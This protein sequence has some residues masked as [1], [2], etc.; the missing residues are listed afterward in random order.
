MRHCSIALDIAS[1]VALF[2]LYVGE[3]LCLRGEGKDDW[4]AL[5]TG[6]CPGLETIAASCSSKASGEDK[7]N[8]ASP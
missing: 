4:K 2:L 1:R 6:I 3:M 7:A 8:D 5:A